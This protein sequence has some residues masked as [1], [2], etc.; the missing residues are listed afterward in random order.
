MY[1]KDEHT[2]TFFVQ[3]ERVVN[4][5]NIRWKM[6]KTTNGSPIFSVN[7]SYELTP[8]DQ[9]GTDIHR[10]MFKYRKCI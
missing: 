9:G 7:S 6:T 3:S 8:N 5:N 1:E 2:N 4:G 10:K